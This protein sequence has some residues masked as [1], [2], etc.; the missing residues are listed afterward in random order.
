M[1]DVVKEKYD[2]INE[3]INS[4]CETW[5]RSDRFPQ[6]IFVW[7]LIYQLFLKFDSNNSKGSD[8]VC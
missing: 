5:I 7:H 1:P 6:D 4:L 8:F 3:V 2:P